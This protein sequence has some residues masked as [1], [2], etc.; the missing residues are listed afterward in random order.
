MPEFKDYY[1]SLG[2][3]REANEKDIKDAFKKL[4]K[5]YH[6]DSSTGSEELFKEINEAHEVLRDKEK[7]SRYDYLYENRKNFSRMDDFGSKSQTFKQRKMYSDLNSF[8]EFYK[9][10]EREHMQERAKERMQQQEPDKF[11]DFFEMFFGKHKERTAA[12]NKTSSSIKGDDYEMDIELSLED[13]FH[14]CVRKVEISGGVNQTTRRLEVT[15]PPGV[16]N[17]TKIKVSHEGKPSKNN[18]ANGDLYLRVRLK[19]HDQFWLEED[20]VHSELVLL[21][22]EAVLGASKKIPTLEDIVELVI[23]PNTHNGR[24]LRLRSKGLKNSKGEIL[25]DHYVHIIID[26]PVNLNNEELSSYKYLRE[27]SERK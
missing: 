23:P 26:I 10:K 21:P 7:R 18:G 2:L 13:A 14:G 25:G 20:N 1:K 27:L 3:T 19:E 22:H 11:S 24:V 12:N 15:I 16:R 6:P 8:K 5:Q 9:E 17:G 4:A